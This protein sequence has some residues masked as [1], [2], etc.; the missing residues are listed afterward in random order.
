MSTKVFIKNLH[1]NIDDTILLEIFRVFGDILSCNVVTNDAG[2]SKGYGYI[3][4]DSNESAMKAIDAVNGMTISDKRVYAELFKPFDQRK[5]AKIFTNVYVKYI[6]P[7]MTDKELREL[8]ERVTDGQINSSK[9]WR[10]KFGVCACLNFTKEED[11]VKSIELMNGYEIKPHSINDDNKETNESNDAVYKLY[12]AR[13]QKREERDILL[14][15][16][17]KNKKLLFRKA[18]HGR[19]L[20]IKNLPDDVDDLALKRMFAKYASHGNILSAK[21][22]IDENTKKSRGVGFVA[23]TTAHD[24]WNA[25][26]QSKN[27]TYNGKALH[28]S[29]AL[30]KRKK[31]N[32][33]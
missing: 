16:I 18:L 32:N 2:K 33:T 8:F 3:N 14:L 6:P 26:Y 20:Y 15:R 5:A 27:L 12:V 22:M 17:S 4:Y 13:A 30:D 23:F 31:N 21:V 25:E 1:E 11:A 24:A 29:W 10:H 19:N 7:S 28:V 9:V